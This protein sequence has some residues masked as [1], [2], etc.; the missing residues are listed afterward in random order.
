MEVAGGLLSRRAE[1]S[2]VGNGPCEGR[3]SPARP[4]GTAEAVFFPPGRVVRGAAMP[5]ALELSDDV[6]PIGL[7]LSERSLVPAEPVRVGGLAAV[8][9]RYPAERF[10]A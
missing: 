9:R 6:D 10:E 2:S 8:C 4:T 7:S 1:H 5:F 3:E